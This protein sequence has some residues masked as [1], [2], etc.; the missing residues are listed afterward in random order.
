MQHNY[1]NSRNQPPLN[2][3][4]FLGN[5][6]DKLIYLSKLAEPENWYY[7]SPKMNENEKETG[8]LFQYIHHTFSKAFDDNLILMNDD[9]AIMNTGLLSKQ[10]EEIFML[11]SRN[12]YPDKQDWFF[13]SF[14]KQSSHDIP[15]EFRHQLPQHI[16]Y[17]KKTP[18]SYYFNPS[19]KIHSNLEHIIDD[20][21]D[22]LPKAMRELPEDILSSVLSAQISIIEKRLLRNNRLAIPQYY[23]KKIMYLIPLA[24]GDEVIALAIEKHDNSYRVNTVLTKEMAYCNARLLMKPESNWLT[25]EQH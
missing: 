21:F 8:V 19:L 16:D 23:N 17:F 6:N 24:F 25:N 11:F 20:N 13:K 2:K 22:R 18:E 9:Y 7:D 15:V 14:Y 10:G 3:F 4:A 5:F 1:N 12:K